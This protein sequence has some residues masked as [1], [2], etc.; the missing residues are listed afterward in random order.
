MCC[1]RHRFLQGLKKGLTR[2]ETERARRPQKPDRLHRRKERRMGRQKK[3]LF[4]QIAFLT[5]GD[6][7]HIE[8]DRW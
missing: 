3:V 2:E 8:H 4:P 6:R 1:T 7:S 5:R